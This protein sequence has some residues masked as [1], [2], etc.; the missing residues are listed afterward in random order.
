MT[1]LTA[2]MIPLA[3]SWGSHLLGEATLITV[4]AIVL[5]YVVSM[6]WPKTHNP[7]LFGFLAAVTL[8]GGLA[9]AGMAGASLALLLLFGIAVLLMSVGIAG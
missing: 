3:A 1:A 5:G 9:Y 6:L 2:S 7:Q 4:G 8:V